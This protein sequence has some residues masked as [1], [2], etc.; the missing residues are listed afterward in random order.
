[1]GSPSDN[2]V[3]K[4]VQA[5]SGQPGGTGKSIAKP[6]TAADYISLASFLHRREQLQRGVKR[7]PQS[8]AIRTAGEQFERREYVAAYETFKPVYD[9]IVTD[10]QRVLARNSELEAKKMATQ[11]GKALAVAKVNVQQMRAHAQQLTDQ[12]EKLRQDL[13]HKPLVRLHL[14]KRSTTTAD[15]PQAADPSTTIVNSTDETRVG[16]EPVAEASILVGDGRYHKAPYAPPTIGSLYTVRDKSQAERII[17]VISISPDGELAQVELL[18]QR[19]PKR[20]S[21]QLA[22]QSLAHQASKGWCHLLVPIAN[23][24]EIAAKPQAPSKT[25]ESERRPELAGHT[26]RIDIQ[27]FGRC[28]AA[29]AFAELKY[30]TQLIKD[31]ADGSFRAGEYEKA[32]FTFEQL[33]TGFNSVVSTSRQAIANARRELIAE[34]GQLSGREVMDRTAAL[35]R[36]E[37]RVFAAEREF[38][39]IL[40]ALRMYVMVKH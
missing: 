1:M 13:E 39:T 19:S 34:K 40:E 9:R 38:T 35:L 23:E 18:D 11:Q 36:R 4:A 27:N 26:L 33:V 32:F 29:I 5:P 37:Q 12:F 28:C 17:N 3:P 10:M 6:I 22:V 21:L 8:E 20:R 15:A 25:N 24:S 14:K 31:V 16:A 30:N 7:E 2:H